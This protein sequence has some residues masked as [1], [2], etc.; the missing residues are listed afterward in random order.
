MAEEFFGAVAF[1]RLDRLIFGETQRVVSGGE[2]PA[3]VLRPLPE[4]ATVV[5]QKEGLI[6]LRLMPENRAP[7]AKHFPGAERHGEIDLVQLPFRPGSALE[8]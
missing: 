6:L 5:A 1:E 7:A 3:P 2:T 8:P 4:L